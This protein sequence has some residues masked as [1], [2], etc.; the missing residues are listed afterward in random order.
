MNGQERNQR[1]LWGSKIAFIFAATGSAIGLGNIWRFS[2]MC[3]ENGGG[4]FLIPYFVALATAGIPLLILEYGLGHR[5]QG[6]A[7][8]SFCRVGRRWEALG[9]WPVVF[10]MFGIELYYCVIISWCVNFFRF[11]FDLSWGP[12]TNSFFFG[13]FLGMSDSVWPPG[14]PQVAILVGLAIVW[15][16]NW[17]ICY[18]GIQS[19]IERACTLFIPFLFVLVAVLVVRGL[20]LPGA[21][22][23]IK[24]YLKPDF[25]VLLKPRVWMA[26]YSQI[27]FTLS[28]GFGI[29]IAYAS[30]LPR[31]SDITANATITGVVNCGFSFVAGFAVFSTLGYMAHTTGKPFEEVVKGSIGL[32]FVAYPEA[33][34]KMPVLQSVVGMIFFLLLI[35]AGL[36][37]S[38]SIIEA[39]ASAVMDKYAM[40]RRKTISILCA[41]GFLGGVIFTTRSGI[42]WLDIV[43]RF[44]GYY[45]LAIVGLLECIVIGWFYGSHVLREHVNRTSNFSIGRTWDLCIKVFTPVILCV[46][47]TTSIYGDVVKS[48]GGYSRK[49]V[50]LIGFG[51]MVATVVVALIFKRSSWRNVDI[52]SDDVRQ[53]D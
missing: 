29:M 22:Q 35:L 1:G 38:I 47:I 10:V 37:S 53:T 46:I 21:V 13:K 14:M 44:L 19:G 2:Y 31:D 26:A 8:V 27:F 12:D 45:G 48:Y 6:S 39:F 9:W 23:G 3:Y 30:Y 34:S 32:A 11:S 49:A 41:L 18:R 25:A 33:I 51:W 50:L 15:I 52:V 40:S 17:L 16:L 28:L 43:D 20:M 42:I 5:M 36:S 7:P 4:A 24:W